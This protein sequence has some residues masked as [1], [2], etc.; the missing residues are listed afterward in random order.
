MDKAEQPPDKAPGKEIPKISAPPSHG[1]PQARFDAFKGNPLKKPSSHRVGGGGCASK[2]DLRKSM[3]K[4][5]HMT[6][7]N[8]GKS[9][10]FCFVENA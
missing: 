8:G 5:I 7:L 4:N 10:I 1:Q 6:K 3:G 2:S 9:Y